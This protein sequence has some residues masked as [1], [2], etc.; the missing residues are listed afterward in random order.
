MRRRFWIALAAVAIGAG[1]LALVVPGRLRAWEREHSLAT[2]H[3]VYS[4]YAC[5]TLPCPAYQLDVFGDGTVIYQGFH[6]VAVPGAFIY[7]IPRDSLQA[8]IEDFRVSGFWQKPHGGAPTPAGGGCR[9]TMYV[10]RNIRKTGCLDLVGDDGMTLSEPQLSADVAQLEA[11]TQLDALVKGHVVAG[12]TPSPN[13][14][15]GMRPYHPDG[16]FPSP[17]A[18][19]DKRPVL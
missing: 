7:H 10:D 9:V 14:V 8:Y 15:R 5:A 3:I 16:L 19:S 6:N 18:M 4:R 2:T 11:L 17:A 13:P 12:A 1:V